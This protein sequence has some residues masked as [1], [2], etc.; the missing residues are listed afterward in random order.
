MLNLS[1]KIIYVHA[2]MTKYDITDIEEIVFE[3]LLDS[4]SMV[5]FVAC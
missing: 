5:M 4:T 2:V 1:M 3:N